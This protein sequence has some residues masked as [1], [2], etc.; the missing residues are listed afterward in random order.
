MDCQSHIELQ[1]KLLI[2]T[3]ERSNMHEYN[4]CNYK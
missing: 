3:A 1:E 4:Y 2:N